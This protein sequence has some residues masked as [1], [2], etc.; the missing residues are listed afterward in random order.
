MNNKLNTCS[1]STSD[2]AKSKG[3]FPKLLDELLYELGRYDNASV[4]ISDKLSKMYYYEESLESLQAG[5][6]NPIAGVVS[7]IGSL[8]SL[9]NKLSV[10]NDGLFYSVRHL[11]EII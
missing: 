7:E 2:I 10:L 1:D 4:Q 9:I 6:V 11:N 5:V 8:K 3:E